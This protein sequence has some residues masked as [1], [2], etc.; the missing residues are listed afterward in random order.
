MSRSVVVLCLCVGVVLVGIQGVSFANT[1]QAVDI[2]EIN[3]L[4]ATGRSILVDVVFY[5]IA[6]GLGATGLVMMPK[7]PGQGGVA[8]GGGV[9]SAFIPSV[10]DGSR[11]AAPTAAAATS[12]L[13]GMAIQTPFWLTPG[14][15]LGTFVFAIL[16]QGIRSWYRR[17]TH[18]AR[19]S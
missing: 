14:L 11:A 10:I 4:K 7:S 15:L 16:I 13:V 9:T 6:L 5:M 2:P 19:V 1:G 3:N 12:D 8:L 17:H 18:V